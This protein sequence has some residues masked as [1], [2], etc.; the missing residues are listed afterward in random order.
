M[1][2]IL[3]RLLNE[4]W[5]LLVGAIFCVATFLLIYYVCIP[6]KN[7][8]N[9]NDFVG[10]VIGAAICGVIGTCIT[11]GSV[12]R[13]LFGKELLDSLGISISMY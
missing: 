8:A 2:E 10:G 3:Q 7:D 4:K 9:T 12:W 1:G 11:V 13:I 5:T 6:H